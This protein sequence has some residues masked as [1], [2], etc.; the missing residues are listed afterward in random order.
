MEANLGCPWRA[1]K[2]SAPAVSTAWAAEIMLLARRFRELPA[3]VRMLS[4]KLSRASAPRGLAG[5]D[6]G[7]CYER[8]FA[9]FYGRILEPRLP[10]MF[11]AA[12]YEE[13]RL[14]CATW[15]FISSKT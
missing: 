12:E 5:W 9:L 8:E 7:I 15:E 1:R 2:L 14:V 10:V 13:Y 4:Q 11:Q 3:C 6:F